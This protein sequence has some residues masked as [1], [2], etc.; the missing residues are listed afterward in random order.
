MDSVLDGD[1]FDFWVLFL[2]SEGYDLMDFLKLKSA[3]L[4][5]PESA[6]ERVTVIRS[7]IGRL[8]LPS[9][10]ATCSEVLKD[11]VEWTPVFK[12]EM[13]LSEIVKTL[14]ENH[15]ARLDF[16][17]LLSNQPIVVGE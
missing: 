13:S 8:F 9:G 10:F 14:P 1:G 4:L 11:G 15:T 12:R 17:E 2:Y 7:W 3:Q 5:H 16:E 6:G